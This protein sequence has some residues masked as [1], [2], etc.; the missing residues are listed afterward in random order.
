MKLELVNKLKNAA[1]VADVNSHGTTMSDVVNECL[2]DISESS[3]WFEKA[4][5]ELITLYRSIEDFAQPRLLSH[6]IEVGRMLEAG[7]HK[8]KGKDYGL[9]VEER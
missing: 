9:P 1:H 8:E 6:L 2:A 7:L 5:D 3:E 4:H